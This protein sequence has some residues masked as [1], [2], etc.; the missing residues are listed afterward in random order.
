MLSD[1]MKLCQLGCDD[2]LCVGAAEATDEGHSLLK[3]DY[4]DSLITRSTIEVLIT[5]TD[6][7]Q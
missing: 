6:C 7:D 3:F 5:H 4:L 2:R 1:L